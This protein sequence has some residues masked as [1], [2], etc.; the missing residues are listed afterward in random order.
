MYFYG[1][2]ATLALLSQ[3]NT[4]FITYGIKYDRGGD[5]D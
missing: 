4:Q 1:N 5:N 2:D 3:W